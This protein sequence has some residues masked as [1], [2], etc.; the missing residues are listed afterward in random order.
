MREYLRRRRS[1]SVETTLSG[2][3][4]LDAAASARADGWRVG[5]VYIGLASSRLA[6]E[7]LKRRELA[8]GHGVPAADVHRR[9]ERSLRRLPSA[10]RLADTV[11]IFDNSSAKPMKKVLE[12]RRGKIIFLARNAPKWLSRSIRSMRASRRRG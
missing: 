3:L 2:Q 4:H 10:Y 12:A 6:I 9:Y 8:G 1:F 7:R 11:Q 5:L